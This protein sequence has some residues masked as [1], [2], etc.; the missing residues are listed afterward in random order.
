MFL[1]PLVM[2][3]TV[4]TGLLWATM[5]VLRYFGFVFFA[6]YLLLSYYLTVRCKINVG[7]NNIAAMG[8]HPIAVSWISP[9]RARDKERRFD[10]VKSLL[11]TLGSVAVPVL[12]IMCRTYK[13]LLAL[14][15]TLEIS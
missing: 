2:V 1:L 15:L 7:T 13:T 4:G 5:F 6:G 11:T 12:F 9:F 8:I 14:V 10:L 3:V